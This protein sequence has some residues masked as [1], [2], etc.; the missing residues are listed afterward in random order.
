MHAKAMEEMTTELDRISKFEPQVK[1]L[2]E[3]IEKKKENFT[4]KKNKFET[5][6]EELTD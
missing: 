1:V 6:I 5:R 2:R 3:R 4:K